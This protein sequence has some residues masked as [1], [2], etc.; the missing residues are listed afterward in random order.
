MKQ[1]IW[2]LLTALAGVVGLAA[3]WLTKQMLELLVGDALERPV[4]AYAGP[5]GK[6]LLVIAFGLGV[7]LVAPV[8]MIR[9]N[10]SRLLQERRPRYGWLDFSIVIV[11]GLSSWTRPTPA[12]RPWTVRPR[13]HTIRLPDD[14][15][16]AASPT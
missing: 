3:C 14:G 16:M 2:G 13:P 11:G 12:S 6:R 4:D 15:R 9:E 1:T 10:S 8:V 5:P 7:L